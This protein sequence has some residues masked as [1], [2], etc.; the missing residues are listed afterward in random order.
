MV[1]RVAET[2]GST[3]RVLELRVRVLRAGAA[4]ATSDAVVVLTGGPGTSSVNGAARIARRYAPLRE[5]RDIVLLDQRGT[6]PSS[7][8]SCRHPA[9]TGELFDG[10][11]ARS[12]V[13]ACRAEAEATIRFDRY[14][15]DDAVHDL[16]L[17]RA[18]LGYDLVNLVGE[19]YGTRAAMAYARRHPERVRTLV[20]DGVA[21]FGLRAPL[22]YASSA[23]QALD[24][25]WVDCAAQPACARAFPDVRR[26]FDSVLARLATPVQVQVQLP[27]EAPVGARFDRDDF[28]YAVRGLMY[29]A[30]RVRLPRMIHAA[31]VTGD[32]APLAEAFA[33]RSRDLASAIG[34]HLTVFCAEDVPHIQDRAVVA[35]TAGTFL[36]D[37]LVREYRALCSM[38]PR[39]GIAADYRRPLRSDA[40]ILMLSGG[41]DPVTP[42]LLAAE[43]AALLPN[44]VHVVLPF[45]LHVLGGSPEAE[46][47][48][49]GLMATVIVRASTRDLDASCVSRLQAAPFE[50][51]AGN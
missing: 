13:R 33:R 22:T 17:V 32:L 42:P 15:T 7:P 18:A 48:K 51:V 37:A 14:S 36:G 2:P 1:A 27:G 24:S 34:V 50:I 20:L 26:E 29:G 23:Q 30:G 3:A 9:G 38:W 5:T 35:A 40:P 46:A 21:P 47:C 39:I 49:V 25:L 4:G 41:R 19:S 11:A 45:G 28:G 44:S 31:F 6:G 43:I 12:T 10:I 8:L 16:D